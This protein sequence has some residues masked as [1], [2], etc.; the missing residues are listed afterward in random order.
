V[1]KYVSPGK[2]ELLL[3]PYPLIPLSPQGV[4]YQK[5]LL[6]SP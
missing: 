5:C 4:L 2:P 3:G 1:F 6:M